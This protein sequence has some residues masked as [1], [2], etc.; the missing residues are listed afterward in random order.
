MHAVIQSRCKY[1]RGVI[2]TVLAALLCLFHAPVL[3]EETPTG[4]KASSRQGVCLLSFESSEQ[5]SARSRLENLLKKKLRA[6]EAGT[7][8]NSA[9]FH[10]QTAL[11]YAAASNDFFA[12]CWLVAKGADVR[13]VSEKRKRARDY[14]T[15]A[16]IRKLL[17]VV[18]EGTSARD[19]PAN[20]PFPVGSAEYL[21]LRVR[22]ASQT[23]EG[24][25]P[26]QMT[27]DMAGEEL[28]LALA[29]RLPHGDFPPAQQLASALLQGELPS[30]SSLLKKYPQLLHDHDLLRYARSA[31]AVR[32]L[33]DAG[34]N[35]GET[36]YATNQSGQDTLSFLVP[37]LHS[38]VHV[39]HALLQ[40]GCPLPVY[41]D[42][43]NILHTLASLPHAAALVDELVSA[44]A[45]LNQAT[46]TTEETP[47]SAALRHR[48]LDVA[49]AL[50]RLGAHV[51]D[52]CAAALFQSPD[53]SPVNPQHVPALITLLHANGW[54]ADDRAWRLFLSEY[55]ATPRPST[56]L[57]E[58]TEASD[59]NI[60]QSLVDASGGKVPANAAALLPMP[61]P[62]LPAPH[63]TR[64]MGRLL[65]L[66]AAAN[67]NAVS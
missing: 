8:V 49:A 56:D 9:A 4:D 25:S 62:I 51:D 52:T 6:I 46:H 10:K 61:S 7:D 2:S 29:L 44:G 28:I 37:A 20:L 48:N 36:W 16:R 64:L 13:L 53:H 58:S 41:A 43:S 54:A 57:P 18:A 24:A 3:A 17:R 26:I 50:I 38:N 21:A 33:M 39:V 67:C 40:A 60:L 12:V 30:V 35:P 47:L 55:L 23:A 34:M 14:S 32:T 5:S 42:G 63:M 31:D 1:Q 45:D 22:R 15:D 66:G 27:A 65:Q 19:E 59:L 11:M